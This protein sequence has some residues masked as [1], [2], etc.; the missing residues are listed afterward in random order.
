VKS[1]YEFLQAMEMNGVQPTA[2]T[3]TTTQPTATTPGATKPGATNTQPEY[4]N[5]LNAFATNPAAIRSLE[6]AGRITDPNTKK[7]LMGIAKDVAT[8]ANAKKLTG[9]KSTGANP[10]PSAGSGMVSGVK[11]AS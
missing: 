2:T 3:P 9:G 7:A 10:V 6:K 1:F 11:P 5:I 8:I 4:L